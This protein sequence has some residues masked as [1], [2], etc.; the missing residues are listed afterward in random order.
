MLA[1][2]ISGVI[3]PS[4]IRDA[5]AS[6]NRGRTI[7]RSGLTGRVFQWIRQ[8]RIILPV[9]IGYNERDELEDEYANIEEDGMQLSRWSGYRHV[10]PVSPIRNNSSITRTPS[11]K[12]QQYAIGLV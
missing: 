5:R 7:Y 2:R 1:S 12:V 8:V 10:G 11:N 6:D 9:L 3:L 4:K